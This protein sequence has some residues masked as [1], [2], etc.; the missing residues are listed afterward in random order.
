[1]VEVADILRAAAPAYLE[2]FT[3]RQRR[4]LRDIQACRTAA[5]GGHLYQ[6]DRCGRQQYAYHSCRN[7]HCSKCQGDNA[8]RWL[9]LQRARLLP[10][11]YYFL[12]FALPARA[13]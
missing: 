3:S 1:M 11:A 10:C 9:D 6:C 5:L 7:R 12:T 13:D 2:A 8:Q 4:A